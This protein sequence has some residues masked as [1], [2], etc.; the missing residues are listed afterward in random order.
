MLLCIVALMLYWANPFKRTNPST[1]LTASEYPSAYS[2]SSEGLAQDKSGK[3]GLDL[4]LDAQSAMSL[5]KS[6]L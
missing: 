4:M 3:S 2:L 1:K 6:A 5:K